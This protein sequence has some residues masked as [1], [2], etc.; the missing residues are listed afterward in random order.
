MVLVKLP[1]PFTTLHTQRNE[2][3]TLHWETSLLQAQLAKKFLKDA[4]LL[5]QIKEV[6]IGFR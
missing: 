2:T 1:K 6:D 3:Q 4:P 5:F